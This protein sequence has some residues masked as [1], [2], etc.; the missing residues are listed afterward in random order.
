VYVAGQNA[1]AVFEGGTITGCN[2]TNP[3]Q[4]HGGAV[5]LYSTGSIADFYASGNIARTVMTGNTAIN[6]SI[7]Y[8]TAATFVNVNGSGVQMSAFLTATGYNS[9]AIFWY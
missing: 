1:K 5:C 2:A 3:D 9:A 4:G 7:L 8:K 6:G